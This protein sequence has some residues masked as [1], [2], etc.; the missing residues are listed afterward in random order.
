ML[1]SEGVK[2]EEK[3]ENDLLAEANEDLTSKKECTS[4]DCSDSSSSE[5]EHS[6]S[7]SSPA[8]QSP[9]RKASAK[10]TRG[11]LYQEMRRYN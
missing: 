9:K 10:L 11:Q 7:L 3:E 6:S 1:S 4:S 8:D 2:N 5:E